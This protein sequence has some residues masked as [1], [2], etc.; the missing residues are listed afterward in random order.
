M[1]S[2]RDALG[3]DGAVTA[4]REVN[5]WPVLSKCALRK[6][7]PIPL[8][9]AESAVESQLKVFPLLLERAGH[10]KIPFSLVFYSILP[11]RAWKQVNNGAAKEKKMCSCCLAI[12]LSTLKISFWW[13]VEGL[14]M[15]FPTP[16]VTQ[17]KC[18]K[19][20]STSRLFSELGSGDGISPKCT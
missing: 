7:F 15:L 6:N 14:E 11:G 18:I 4:V 19:T 16:S 10:H 12:T 8:P 17:I 1:E 20:S 13:G 5:S 3:M 2:F 9:L